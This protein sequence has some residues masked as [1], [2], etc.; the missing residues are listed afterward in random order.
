MHLLSQVLTI[1][2]HELYFGIC[3][4]SGKVLPSTSISMI[5]KKYETFGYHV[6]GIDKGPVLLLLDFVFMDTF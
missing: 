5:K 4:P 2:I 3:A 6:T 1:F